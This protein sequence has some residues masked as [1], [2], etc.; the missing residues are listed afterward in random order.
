M[1]PTDEPYGRRALADRGRGPIWKHDAR[2]PANDL[3]AHLVYGLVTA[4]AMQALS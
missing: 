3:S 2:T 1:A 4:A